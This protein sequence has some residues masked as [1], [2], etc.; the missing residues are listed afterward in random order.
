MPLREKKYIL[1]LVMDSNRSDI[2]FLNH[3]TKEDSFQH[4]TILLSKKE[5]EEFLKHNDLTIQSN[6]SEQMDDII[7]H[8]C[9][10]DIVYGQAWNSELHKKIWI[11]R[12]ANA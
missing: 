6:F 11:E 12:H 5:R 1:S 9:R 8:I 3:E 2:D 4:T 7:N 10:G